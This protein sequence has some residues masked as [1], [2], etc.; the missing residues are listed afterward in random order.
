MSKIIDLQSYKNKERKEIEDKAYEQY[1]IVKVKDGS[2]IYPEVAFI[3]NSA[4]LKL[5]FNEVLSGMSIEGL[6]EKEAIDEINN[7]VPMKGQSV[8]I[9]LFKTEED[10]ML[11]FDIFNVTLN[12]N[13]FITTPME[14]N[15]VNR[16]IFTAIVA[17]AIKKVEVDVTFLLQLSFDE[18][19]KLV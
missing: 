11:T 10:D 2:Y 5:F 8:K 19:E 4:E 1:G 12:K 9:M 15:E 13:I 18:V 6:L 3:S 16:K 14:F 17:G 7:I